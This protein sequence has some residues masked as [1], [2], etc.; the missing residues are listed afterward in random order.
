MPTTK[1]AAMFERT[2]VGRDSVGKRETGK[3]ENGVKEC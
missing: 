3:C 1:P 2:F